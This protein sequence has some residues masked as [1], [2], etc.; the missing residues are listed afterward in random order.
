MARIRSPNYPA[1]G[2]AEA[3][4]KTKT[5]HEKEQHLAATKDVI[6][7]HLGYSS[8]NG[9][10]LKILSALSKYGLVEEAN[11]D[12]IKVSSQALSILHP[13]SSEEKASAIRDAAGRPILFV[14]IANEWP[15]GT[16]SD[17]NLKSYLIRKSFAADAIDRVIKSYRE[18]IDLVA[19]E[20][21]VYN[22]A[23]ESNVSQTK[24][25]IP[26]QHSHANTQTAQKP[27][28]LPQHAGPM[29]V[30]FDGD[31]LEVSAM[32]T[33]VDAVDQLIRALTATKAL[34]PSKPKS[35]NGQNN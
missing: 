17:E 35:D 2:L 8:L 7:K 31:R 21:G 13:R 23:N 15:D 28:I 22:P 19:S 18:T 16:P 32:L 20:S 4:S 24:D 11:G 14:E 5:I 33:D 26:M 27:A 9:S 29:R 6:A 34:L 25:S 12:R 3:I 1:I 10:A 30:A